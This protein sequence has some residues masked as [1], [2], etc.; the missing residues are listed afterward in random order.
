MSAEDGS[1]HLSIP[2]WFPQPLEDAARKLHDLTVHSR[3]PEDRE[4]VQR[5]VKNER[6]KAVWMELQKRRRADRAFVHEAE[7]LAHAVPAKQGAL[8]NEVVFR[9]IFQ[10]Y[11]RLDRAKKEY[12]RNLRELKRAWEANPDLKRIT[13]FADLEEAMA[14]VRSDVDPEIMDQAR[15]EASTYQFAAMEV[16]FRKA[17]S[18]GRYFGSPHFWTKTRHSYVEQ[19]SKARSEALFLERVGRHHIKDQNDAYTLRQC[20]KKLQRSLYETA[21]KY[22]AYANLLADRHLD[23]A[24]SIEFVRQMAGTLKDLFGKRL[25]STVATIAS[26][27]LDRAITP[28]NVKDWCRPPFVKRSSK[29]RSPPGKKRVKSPRFSP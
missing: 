2:E 14:A 9:Q 20:G 25:N 3:S 12:R 22:E 21:E 18:L 6:M 11:T 1:L 13:G 10:A 5:L 8:L 29:T 15:V 19:A 28:A 23:S 26:V 4:T 17:V 27:A 7:A 16:V 24:A